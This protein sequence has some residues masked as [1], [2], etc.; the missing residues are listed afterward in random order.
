MVIDV[1]ATMADGVWL[2][3]PKAHALLPYLKDDIRVATGMMAEAFR[4]AGLTG[5]APGRR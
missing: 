1:Y 3:D 2:Y 5:K 4:R